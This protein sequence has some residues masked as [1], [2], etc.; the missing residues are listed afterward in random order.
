MIAAVTL[1]EIPILG[2]IT[3][4][5]AAVVMLVL[6]RFLGGTV[7]Q[8]QQVALLGWPRDPE[9]ITPAHAITGFVLIGGLGGLVFV[10]I[11]PAMGFIADRG[12]PPSSAAAGLV[13]AAIFV[14]YVEIGGRLDR[15]DPPEIRMR[16]AWFVGAAAYALVLLLGFEL[17]ADWFI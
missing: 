1:P 17:F 16:S 11:V 9:A 12:I 14:L 10:L 7:E 8:L 5:L 4:M 13:A 3:G 15:D 6:V 2:V